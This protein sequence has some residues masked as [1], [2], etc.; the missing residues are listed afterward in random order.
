MDRGAWPATAH[1]GCRVG[2]EL[3]WIYEQIMND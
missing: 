2:H 1:E 3:C